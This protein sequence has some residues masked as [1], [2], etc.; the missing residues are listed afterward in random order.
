MDCFGCQ[1]IICSND[2]VYGCTSCK[3]FLHKSCAELPKEIRYP[4]N[5][6]NFFFHLFKKDFEVKCNLCDKKYE[7]T[8]TFKCRWCYLH[9]CVKCYL[10][11]TRRNFK[12]DYYEHLL[13]F[14]GEM[15][16][17]P[18]RQCNNYNS[19]CKRLAISKCEEISYTSWGFFCFQCDFKVHLLCGPLPSIIK[20]ESHVDPLILVDSLVEKNYAEY[21]CDICEMERDP[22]IRVY[23][24]QWCKYVALVHCL[25]S[26]VCWLIKF[27]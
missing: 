1:S 14:H 2:Q 13:C 12:Y 23:C 22:R 25:A 21:Y 11:L 3:Y 17:Q 9:L 8:F 5:E 20:H 6:D 16:T 24:Y 27:L 18:F 26:E 7:T 15:K 10:T 19:Y 4:L